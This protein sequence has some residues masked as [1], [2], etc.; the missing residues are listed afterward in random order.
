MNSSKCTRTIIS[1]CT[2]HDFPP[3]RL[4]IEIVEQILLEGWLSSMS[5]LERIAFKNTV[6]LVSKVWLATLTRICFHDVYLLAP[7]FWERQWW[8]VESGS[9][10]SPV[11]LVEADTYPVLCRSITQQVLSSKTTPPGHLDPQRQWRGHRIWDLLSMF[12]R[13]SYL[14]NLRELVLECYHPDVISNQYISFQAPIVQLEVAYDITSKVPPWLIDALCG[15]GNRK[16]NGGVPWALPHFEFILASP[17][18]TLAVGKVL[19]L[20]PHLELAQE[21]FTIG[22]YLIS[23]S[24]RVPQNCVVILGPM[25]PSNCHVEK[26]RGSIHRGSEIV[27]GSVLGF[28]LETGIER[29][30]PRSHDRPSYGSNVAHVF[31][32]RSG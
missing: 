18:D 17:N 2:A 16:S 19:K 26:G 14:P 15:S 22:V 20:C 13:L 29:D 32:H 28:I 11:G 27:R 7:A 5:P 23:S 3:P 25:A 24:R 8:M 1:P 4:P 6:A 12:H 31:V 10:K 21:A 9:T 30:R